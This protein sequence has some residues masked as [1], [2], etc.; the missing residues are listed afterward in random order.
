M[1]NPKYKVKE[2]SMQVGY[3]NVSYFCSVF[4]KDMEK[5]PMNT[6]KILIAVLKIDMFLVKN[7]IQK[8]QNAVFLC[9]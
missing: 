6:E 2:V 9:I 7:S 4:T 8:L 3:E 5:R 1:K